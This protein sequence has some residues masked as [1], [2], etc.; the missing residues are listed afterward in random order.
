MMT[1]T[2]I[3]AATIRIKTNARNLFNHFIPGLYS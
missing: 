2:A 1:A 3:M